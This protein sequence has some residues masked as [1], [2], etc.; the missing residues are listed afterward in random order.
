LA[1]L[2]NLAS[3][4]YLPS[5]IVFPSSGSVY[6]QPLAAT[7]G[8]GSYTY[9]S[10]NLPAGLNLSKDGTISGT[11]ESPSPNPHIPNPPPPVGNIMT[12]T[13]TVT[14]TDTNGCTGSQ[15]FTVVTG[16]VPTIAAQP[17]SITNSVGTT[18]LFGVTATGLAPLGYQWLINGTN[19]TDSARTTGS[20]SN[21]LAIASLL[22]NDAGGYQVVVANNFGSITSAVA[23]L[24]VTTTT[25]APAPPTFQTFTLAGRNLNVSWSATAGSTYQLQCTTNLT[26]TNWNNLGSP[27]TASGGTITATDPMTNS[28]RFYRVMLQQ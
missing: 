15:N 18:A 27:I 6:N 21:T 7:G 3:S 16:V 22:T 1:A 20:Q 26:Q 28:Q 11:V 19:L 14:A 10:A 24:T 5:S 12:Y 9:S 23:T 17:Q 13:F 4:T 2:N 8:A 25:N